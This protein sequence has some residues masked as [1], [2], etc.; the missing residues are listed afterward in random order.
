MYQLFK[1]L[2][3]ALS[4]EK[5]HRITMTLL[6]IA[7]AT[8]PG[9]AL[10]RSWYFPKKN[11][12]V[13]ALGLNFPNVV[14]LAAGFDKDGKH[15]EALACLGFGH[16][17]VGTVT[18]VEQA[19]N[20]QPRLFRLPADRALINRMGFNN[21]GVEALAA[22]LK[23][24]REKGVPGGLII[25]GNIGKN[26]NTPNEEAESDYLRCFEA[27]YPYVDYF[28]VNVSSP[29]TPNLR[30]LQ[31][32][33][34]LTRLL[35]S[36][37]NLNRQQAAPKPIL[38]KIAPDLGEEQLLEIAQI[39]QETELAGVI[40][41]NTTISRAGLQTPEATVSEIGAG[42]L[43]GAP[44]RARATEVIRFLR[45]ALPPQTVI[46]GV[47]GIDSA[48]AAQDKLAAGATLVQVYSGFVYE[49][50][51]LVRRVVEG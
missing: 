8:A 3:F 51:G 14:G 36:L 15:I 2:L 11:A 16:I 45:Q 20:P 9:R 22:R 50:P 44:V 13:Q 21:E 32:K 4:P 49:G 5:A 40:A 41:T 31:E 34:P 6:E 43:S 7:C 42:G 1:P 48:E 30:A 37:Q 35:Q 28:V 39:V 38:L 26:K 24:L 46:I 25:G 23:R 19:G 12:A 10:L 47:G 18:P 17:E 29:N 27:L 33:E